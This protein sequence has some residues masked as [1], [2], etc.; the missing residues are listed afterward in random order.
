ML[1]IPN[2][3]RGAASGGGGRRLRVSGFLILLAAVVATAPAAAEDIDDDLLASFRKIVAQPVVLIA[4]RA[5]NERH[6]SMDQATIDALDKRWRAETKSDDQPLIAQLMGSPLSNYL[7]K[8][9]AES[10]GLIT[11][12]FVT[13]N[14]GLN[15]GQSSVTT[16]YWQG[17]E[18]KYRKTFLVGPDAVH[19]AE[20][21]IHAETGTRRRQVDFTV[22]DPDTGK[23]IGAATV[24]VDLDELA[25]RRAKATKG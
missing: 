11:E 12:V 24:E 14:L 6:T 4:V 2:R 10:Y 8:V 9:K 3:N 13:D 1:R 16:D 5:Q 25:E 19:L 22:V 17:D 18:A 15:V 23:P 7:I 21:E 20:V